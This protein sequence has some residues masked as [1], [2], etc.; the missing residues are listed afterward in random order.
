[1]G[2]YLA[3]EQ[4]HPGPRPLETHSA[5]SPSVQFLESS[6]VP[7]QSRPPFW[8]GGRHALAAAPGAHTRC[9]RLTTCSTL[10]TRRRLWGLACSPWAHGHAQAPAHTRPCAQQ[11]CTHTHS[12]EAGPGASA[13]PPG[14]SL[15]WAHGGAGSLLEGL[16]LAEESASVERGR[17]GAGQR[18]LLPA[19]TWPG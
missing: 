19:L 12:T 8:G 13:V 14:C 17:V 10:S 1:M 7:L 2:A 4:P 3:P 5:H 15:T 9:Y 16:A 18:A 11:R 6:S